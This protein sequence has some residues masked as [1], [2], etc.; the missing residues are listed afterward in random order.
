MALHPAGDK[1]E[2]I[3][4]VMSLT[5]LVFLRKRLYLLP[6]VTAIWII[7]S[8]FISYGIAVGYGHT[9]P[10]F[11]Y[12]SHTAI[13]APERCVF[14]QL[15][16]VGALMQIFRQKKFDNVRGW[17]K[18][19]IVGIILGVIS[20]FGISMVAN[21]QTVVLRGPHYVGAGLAFGLGLI[22]CWLQTRITW[23]LREE[24]IGNRKIA[25]LQLI[26]SIALTGFDS[27][28]GVYLT[29]TISEWL[30]AISVLTYTL[31]YT[32]DFKSMI[33]ESPKVT[34][35]FDQLQQKHNNNTTNTTTTV[36]SSTDSELRNR[37]VTDN[38]VSNV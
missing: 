33:L 21:F 16:N 34:L 28:R 6:I 17:Q 12:I 36:A 5:C 27:L 20:A 9:E 11:P 8:F 3:P 30:L 14:G 13:E 32:W 26:N 25:I 15:V 35:D 18:A 37:P 1:E 2:E 24:N 19:N 10:D 29:S 22:Y 7:C 31:T 38:A 23:R 4:G